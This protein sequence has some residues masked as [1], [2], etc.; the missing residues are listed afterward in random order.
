[1]RGPDEVVGRWYL[2]MPCTVRGP[3]GELAVWGSATY[4]DVFVRRDGVWRAREL[5]LTSRFW[6]PYERGWVEQP[7]VGISH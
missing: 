3:A 7:F 6:T 4:E 5:K 1:M 2:T